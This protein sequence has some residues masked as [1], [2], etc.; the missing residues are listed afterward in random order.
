MEL[1]EKGKQMRKEVRKKQT[2]IWDFDQNNFP[3]AQNLLNI[4]VCTISTQENLM[5]IILSLNLEFCISET[6]VMFLS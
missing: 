2:K 3:S 6:D 4:Y 5:Y 1:L